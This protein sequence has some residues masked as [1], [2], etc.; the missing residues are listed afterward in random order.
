MLKNY[1][2]QS[3]VCEVQRKIFSLAQGLNFF[4][5]NFA[6]RWWWVFCWLHWK[7]TDLQVYL[8]FIPKGDTKLMLTTSKH[9]VQCIHVQ[10]RPSSLLP[11]LP[12]SDPKKTACSAKDATSMSCSTFCGTD[13][14]YTSISC[15]KYI[16]SKKYISTLMTVFHCHCFT[17]SADNLNQLSTLLHWWSSIYGPQEAQVFHIVSIADPQ[18]CSHLPWMH[19]DVCPYPDQVAQNFHLYLYN[20]PSCFE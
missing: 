5:L 10:P 18:T 8:T 16:S 11:Q 7:N 4:I 6:R 20:L 9:I 13:L 12:D 15:T 3:D 2:E 1:T 14:S 17:L 19:H